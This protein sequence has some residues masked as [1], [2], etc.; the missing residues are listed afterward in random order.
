MRAFRA[1]AAVAAVACAAA[2]PE[3]W[4]ASG[5]TS[6]ALCWEHTSLGDGVVLFNLSCAVEAASGKPSYC[7]VGLHDDS[8]TKMAPAEVFWASI[9]GG[10][11]TIEDRWDASKHSPPVC[12]P[13]QISYNV[14]SAIAADGSFWVAFARQS[15][16]SSAEVI[17]LTP[18]STHN[19]IFAWGTG[20]PANP[21]P[22]AAGYPK[23]IFHWTGTA[24]F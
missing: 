2:A 8:S 14:S 17:P 22:C 16:A 20:G 24:T 18:G 9:V 21:P 13:K 6:P 3:C 15:N 19:S 23:H 1:A 12:V 7:A 10:V 11:A 5:D 4:A